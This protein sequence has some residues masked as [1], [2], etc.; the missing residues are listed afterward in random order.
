VR[1]VVF[2]VSFR[3]NAGAASRAAQRLYAM[4]VKH[5]IHAWRNRLVTLLQLLLP[6]FFVVL[7]G[8]VGKAFLSAYLVFGAP[9]AL[10]LELSQFSKP[11][12]PYM[13]DRA[14][15]LAR[16]YSGVADEYGKPVPVYGGNMDNYLLGTAKRSLGDYNRRHIVAVTANGSS[17][18]FVGHFNSLAVH[19][20][21]VSLSLADNALLRYAVPGNNRIVT[22]NHPLL[23]SAVSH[24]DQTV[25]ALSSLNA[26][27][28]LIIAVGLAF[29]VGLFAVFVVNQR[30]S[31]S[32]HLQFVGGVDAASY[33][34]ATFVWDFFIFS[35][36]SVLVVAVLVAFQIDG[37][38][39]WPAF[40]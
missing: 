1:C 7:V 20:I 32:K 17:G 14:V 30:S 13:Y 6:L 21:A 33:W 12:V 5:A 39:D 3:R 8:V 37:Y 11:V 10:T 36:V 28:P 15:Q 24:A 23:P 34:L 38:S 29:L 9:P 4:I 31:K 25:M 16:S 18:V 40:G 26:F 27:F 22:V 35:V 2:G 19:S